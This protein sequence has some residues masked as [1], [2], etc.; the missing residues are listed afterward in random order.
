M[1]HILAE[2][3][4]REEEED[5]IRIMD[6]LEKELEQIEFEAQ[7]KKEAI[8]NWGRHMR[9][10]RSLIRDYKAL[11]FRMKILPNE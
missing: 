6:E 11:K 7:E 8:E 1:Q 9:H 3:S 2:L 4:D 10:L 5:G